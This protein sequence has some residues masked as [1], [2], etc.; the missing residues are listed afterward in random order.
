MKPIKG[1]VWENVFDKKR[2]TILDVV[3]TPMMIEIHY[4]K[5]GITKP[6]NKPLSLFLSVYEKISI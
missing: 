5:E 4:T 2:A 1:E 3:E 6:V